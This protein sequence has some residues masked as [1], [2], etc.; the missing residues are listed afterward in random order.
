MLRPPRAAELGV[1]QSRNHRMAIHHVHSKSELVG[2]VTTNLENG[3]EIHIA[4]SFDCRDVFQLPVQASDVTFIGD[5]LRP[6]LSCN[7]KDWTTKASLFLIKG[8]NVRFVN[9]TLDGG[10]YS[11]EVILD[12][13]AAEKSGRKKV[14][15]FFLQS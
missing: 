10:Y 7:A 9:L 12:N 15:D 1:R 8:N 3:A 4:N 2:L 13:N 11:K 14:Q 5:G 6:V